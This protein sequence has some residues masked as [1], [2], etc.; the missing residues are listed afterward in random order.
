MSEIEKIWGQTIRT[1]LDYVEKQKAKED[2]DVE[3]VAAEIRFR[4]EF[5][6]YDR[7]D[8]S[9]ARLCEILAQAIVDKFKVGE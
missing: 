5:N 6:M 4:D 3:R 1:L 2:M 7:A 9:R 8:M